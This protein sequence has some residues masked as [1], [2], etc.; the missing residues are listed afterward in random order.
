MMVITSQPLYEG[1]VFDCAFALMVF[2]RLRE[3]NCRI[4]FESPGNGFVLRLDIN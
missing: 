4:R 1:N 2:I 3:S